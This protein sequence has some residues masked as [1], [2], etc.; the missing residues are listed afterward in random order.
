MA[1]AP[2]APADSDDEVD[3]GEEVEGEE[4]EED[5]SSS[6]PLGPSTETKADNKLDPPKQDGK[7][8]ERKDQET[9]RKKSS[10][11]TSSGM[12]TG[13]SPPMSVD[14]REAHQRAMAKLKMVSL[15]ICVYWLT[16]HCSNWKKGQ[17]LSSLF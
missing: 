14:E 16:V 7:N 8:E 3:N 2:P 5:Q 17:E 9:V 6:P 11:V 4:E 15:Y 13:P 10:I 1:S 12:Q